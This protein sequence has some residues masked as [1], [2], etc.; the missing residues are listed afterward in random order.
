MNIQINRNHPGIIILIGPPGAGKT[1]YRKAFIEKTKLASFDC[2][3]ISS[4]ELRTYKKEHNLIWD[5]STLFAEIK[6]RILDIL[7]DNSWVILDA[8]NCNK[9]HR[10]STVK[11]IRKTVPSAQIIGVV[12]NCTLYD[13]LTQNHNRDVIVPDDVVIKMWENL[14]DNPP[15]INEGFDVIIDSNTPITCNLGWKYV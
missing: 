9:L 15:S 5:S 2:C 13:C 1:T 11:K 10:S 7:K 12:F 4:D 8:T 3:Y 14:R 6:Q